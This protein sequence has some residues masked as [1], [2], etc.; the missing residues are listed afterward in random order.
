MGIP[1]VLFFVLLFAC[2]EDLELKGILILLGIWGAGLAVCA[3]TGVS[4]YI[5]TGFEALLDIVLILMFFG[6]DVRIR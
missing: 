6:G 4:A 5:F 2:R 1:L 3:L